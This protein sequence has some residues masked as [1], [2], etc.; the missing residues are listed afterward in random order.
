MQRLER[1]IA[2]LERVSGSLQPPRLVATFIDSQRGLVSA[3]RWSG[4]WIRRA[5]DETEA[6]FSERVDRWANEDA[7]P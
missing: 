6:Q 4:E 1:R 5:H 2:D 7:S 3:R